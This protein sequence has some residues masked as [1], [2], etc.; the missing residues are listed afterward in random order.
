MKIGM[1]LR[2]LEGCAIFGG[3]AG[4]DCGM[5]RA[6]GAI[7]DLRTALDEILSAVKDGRRRHTSGDLGAIDSSMISATIRQAEGALQKTQ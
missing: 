2:H 1:Y 3:R 5:L 6:E 4:C 7:E